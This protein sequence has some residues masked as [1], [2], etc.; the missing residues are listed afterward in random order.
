[1]KTLIF[2][3]LA[4][5]FSATAS[6]NIRFPLKGM[7]AFDQNGFSSN[8][9]HKDTGTPFDQD[10]YDKNG[11]DADG[12]GKLECRYNTSEQTYTVYHYRVFSD[13]LYMYY[14]EG[15]YLGKPRGTQ[16]VDNGYLYTVG[17]QMV[18]NTSIYAKICRQKK[19]T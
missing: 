4:I 18:M 15:Q 16:L 17:E 6:Y 5:S 13:G 14:W 3:I 11:F 1:M 12:L 2:A 8:G 9:I 10:G 19:L 7:N